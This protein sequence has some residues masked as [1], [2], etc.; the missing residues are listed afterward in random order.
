MNH[1]QKTL[2]L[3]AV[4][5]YIPSVRAQFSITPEIGGNVT[6]YHLQTAKMGYKVGA[7]VTY[8]FPG[9]RFAL[10]SGLYYTQRNAGEYLT[11]YMVS[12]DQSGYESFYPLIAPNSSGYGYYYYGKPEASGDDWQSIII[13]KGTMN[14]NYLQIP[15]LARFNRHLASDTR[16]FVALGPYFGYILNGKME[17]EATRVN[18]A[19]ESS[20]S[21]FSYN[22]L[23]KSNLNRFD[24]GL[25]LQAGFEIKQF[26]FGMQ[27]DVSYMRPLNDSWRMF[28]NLIHPDDFY[29]PTYQTFTISIGYKFNLTK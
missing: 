17:G 23:K 14:L 11:A 4:A 25:S 18:K 28:N 26:Q 10:Q 15:I 19:E 5:L 29:K 6:K 20:Y 8:T 24:W 22:P 7:A 3:L 13:N 1:L 2:C 27:Y 12:R 21:D 9:R 16:F